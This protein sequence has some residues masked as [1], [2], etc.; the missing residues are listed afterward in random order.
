MSSNPESHVP[1]HGHEHEVTPGL[2]HIVN[3]LKTVIQWLVGT[4]DDGLNE[5]YILEDSDQEQQ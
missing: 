4:Y 1:E 3:G 5:P 2:S